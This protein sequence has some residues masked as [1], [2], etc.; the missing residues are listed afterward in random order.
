MLTIASPASVFLAPDEYPHELLPH[1]FG[2]LVFW[3]EPP[4]ALP[5]QETAHPATIAAG[6]WVCAHYR[7]RA[8]E[9][10]TQSAARQL[11]KQGYPLEIALAVLTG[12]A[13]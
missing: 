4:M 8:A 10:G 11:R 6:R 5:P 12:R 9:S 1:S 7:A 3:S 2:G 13:Q